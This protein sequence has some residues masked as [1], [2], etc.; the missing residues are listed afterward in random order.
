M[1]YLRSVFGKKQLKLAVAGAVSLLLAF[2]LTLIGKHVAEG[3]D[4]ERMAERWSKTGSFAQVSCF[5]SEFSGFTEDSVKELNYNLEQKFT[6]DSL[7]ANKNARLWLNAYSAG[8]EVYAESPVSSGSFKAVG[9]GGDYF[10]FHP[11][12]TCKRIFV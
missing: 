12:E 2:I 6:E 11:P 4:A 9:V 10:L 8:G 1:E 5:F 3:M 7:S